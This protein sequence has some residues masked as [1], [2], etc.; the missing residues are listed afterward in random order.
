MTE[1][2]KSHHW[3]AILILTT[4]SIAVYGNALRI[5]FFYDD[6]LAVVE[7]PNVRTL[8][9][10]SMSLDAIEGSGASGRPLV[11]YTLA[12]NYALGEL[13]TFGYHLFNVLAHALSVLALFGFARRALARSSAELPATALAFCCALLWGVHPLNSDAI[14]LVITRNEVMAAGFMLGTLYCAERSMAKSAG[15]WMA[16]AFVSACAAMLCKEIA[17]C[18]PLLVLAYDRTFVSGSF[19]V[20]LAAR[21]KFHASLF[22][23]LALLVFVVLSGDRGA[24]VGFGQEL[25]V[26]DYLRTQAQGIVHYLRLSFWPSPLAVDYAGW[27]QVRE[28]GPALLPGSFVLLLF[29]ASLLAFLRGMRSGWVALSFFAILAPSSSVIPLA[30]EWLAEHRMYLPLACVI[31][32]MVLGLHAITKR[33]M[34]APK[35]Q[36]ILG[37][38][39]V[40]AGLLSW[41]TLQRNQDY[42]SDVSIWKDCIEKYPGNGRAHDH[43]GAIYLG[44]REYEQALAYSLEALRLDP[45]LYTVDFNVGAILVQLQRSEEALPYL[46][47]AE[48]HVAGDVRFHS[49]YAVALSQT[50]SIPAAIQELEHAIQI[51]P[52]HATAQRNLGLLYLDVGRSREGL[53]HLELSLQIEQDVP[54]M[55]RF[56]RV[57]STDPDAGLRDGK[58]ALQIANQLIGS[59]PPDPRWFELRG[60]A[61]WELGKKQEAVASMDKA[62]E[63]ARHLNQPQLVQELEA[64]RAS[65]RAN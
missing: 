29:G 8:W 61:Q 17:A 53:K 2:R 11:A 49:T 26:L 62:L 6:M 42:E 27:P 58:R 31:T 51:A 52:Q 13:D 18:L 60:L 10:L 64:W 9:P 25:T 4:A 59:G 55:M 14:N 48:K 44:K 23:T 39:C 38:T 12:L 33:A 47:K 35:P 36:V 3:I 56:A 37:A 7:S 20:A 21:G 19:R 16:L 15:P 28:W 24:S 46:R 30:G 50:D 57:L 65:H 54:T 43:L 22:A 32:L 40:L 1:T 45:T 5:P 63:G 41:G 34:G